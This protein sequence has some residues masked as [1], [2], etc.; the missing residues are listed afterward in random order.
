MITSS[1]GY[2]DK[3]KIYFQSTLWIE[4]YFELE[5]LS[6]DILYEI[7]WVKVHSEIWNEVGALGGWLSDYFLNEIDEIIVV[8][9]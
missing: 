5:R 7:E 8:G 4:N 9:W 6:I 2:I 3:H 1:S